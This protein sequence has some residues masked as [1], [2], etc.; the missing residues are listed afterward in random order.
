[1]IR[2]IFQPASQLPDVDGGFGLTGDLRHQAIDS[3][4]FSVQTTAGDWARKPNKTGII[5]PVVIPPL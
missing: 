5:R 1:M 2:P 3:K 4:G